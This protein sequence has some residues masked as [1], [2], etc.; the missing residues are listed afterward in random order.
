VRA[1]ADQ[2][3][4]GCRPGDPLP[5]LAAFDAAAGRRLTVDEVHDELNLL[6]E[7]FPAAIAGLRD[8]LGP[9]ASAADGIDAFLGQQDLDPSR[10]TRARQGLRAL[11]EG[12]SADLAE[13][14]SLQ[15]MWTEHEYGGGFFGDL[16]DGGYCSLIDALAAP[17][18]VR[19]GFDVASIEVRPDGVRV[20]SASGHVE[21]GSHVVVTVPLG[22]LKDGRPR[23]SP[24]LPQDRRDAIDQMGFG[25]FEKVVLRFDEPFWRAAG[26]PHLMLFPR[27]PAESAMWVIGLDAFGDAPT[28]TCFLFH[29]LT[30]RMRD[31]S[32]DDAVAMVLELLDDVI[33]GS[34]PEP[35]AAAVTNW[36][37]DPYS[38]GSYSHIP[39]GA[40]PADADLLGEPLHG[41]LLFAGEH[42]QSQRLVYTD[43]AMASGIREAKRILQQPHVTLGDTHLDPKGGHASPR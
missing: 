42:T 30:E 20:T 27:D 2:L 8:E 26:L 28:L 1:L 4:I 19:L 38:L 33:G 32:S 43:G 6:Y 40:S 23:F 7:V 25:W 29:G 9:E 39:P 35:I 24:P 34:S 3:E 31:A 17:A 16:P 11:I 41:R 5:E 10:A 37:R 21:D 12:E 15:W 36:A 18:D 14:Q 13:R 22:V